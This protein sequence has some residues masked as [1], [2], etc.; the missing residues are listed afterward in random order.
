MPGWT[1]STFGVRDW[2]ALPVNARNYLARLSEL[3]GAPVD[4]V[5]T[6]PDRDE[7]ILVRHPFH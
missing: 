6:G 1:D 5:S 7:T 3:V 4:I 2:D